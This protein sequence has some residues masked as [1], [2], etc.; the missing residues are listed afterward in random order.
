MLTSIAIIYGKL[1]RNHP[2]NMNHAHKYGKDLLSVII[3]LG[4]NVSG[5]EIV[6][7]VDLDLMNWG[8]GHMY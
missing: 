6:L 4:G 3:T 1:Y 5:V 2:K 8:K 7:I